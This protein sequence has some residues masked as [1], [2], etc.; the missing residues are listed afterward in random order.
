[1]ADSS[2]ERADRRRNLD[3]SVILK[4]AAPVISPTL[5]H[6]FQKTLDSSN[7]TQDWRV[8][9]MWPTKKKK[10]RVTDPFQFI[11]GPY[12]LPVLSVDLFL[13]SFVT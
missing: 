9:Y 8:A 6:S 10:K 4:E 12:R 3:H 5:V 11:T 13:C 2:R 1:M 7:L